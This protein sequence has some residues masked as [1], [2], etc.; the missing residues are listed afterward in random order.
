MMCCWH[1]LEQV[2]ARSSVK[3]Y[4]EMINILYFHITFLHVYNSAGKVWIEIVSKG[5]KLLLTKILIFKL[6]Y[7]PQRR[8][9]YIFITP[10]TWMAVISSHSVSRYKIRCDKVCIDLSKSL[11]ICY[12]FI[13]SHNSCTKRTQAGNQFPGKSV[14]S[15][16]REN[17]VS[18]LRPHL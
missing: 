15:Q 2:R 11:S 6:R 4:E 14:S 12:P 3:N 8:N 13:N 18:I 10:L 1:K 9:R 7:I 5:E 17:F 16:I